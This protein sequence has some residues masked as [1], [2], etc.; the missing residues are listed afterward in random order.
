MV[1]DGGYPV[2][3]PPGSTS[4]WLLICQARH[5]AS[6]ADGLALLSL[7]MVQ[8][9]EKNPKDA[10]TVANLVVVSLHMGKSS[11]RYMG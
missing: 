6:F 1:P 7:G 2:V 11:S 8:A 3:Y 5:L 10:D 4:C 9:F